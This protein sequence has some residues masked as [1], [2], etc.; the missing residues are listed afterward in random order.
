MSLATKRPLEKSTVTI[1]HK[2]FVRSAKSGNAT[3]FYREQYLREDIPCSSQLCDI[4]AKLQ[5]AKAD[6]TVAT[7]VLARDP[8]VTTKRGPHYIIID[9]NIALQAMDVLELKSSFF[10]MIIPQTVL[11]EVRNR[12]MPT[13]TRLRTLTKDSDEKRVY[14][15]HNEF[16]KETHTLR[17]KNETINDRNDRAIRNVAK[18]YSQHIKQHAA[19]SAK[20]FG[21]SVPEVVLLSNDRANRQKAKEEGITVLSLREYIRELKNADDI[22]D[23]LPS[24]DSVSSE[25]EFS[26]PEYYP[27]SRILGGVKN[28]TLFRGKLQINRYNFLEGTVAT[29]AYPRPMLILGRKNLNRGFDGDTVV[30]ELLP[31]SQWKYPVSEVVEEERLD[32]ADGAD[33]E[34][35]VISDTERK[36]LAQEALKAQQDEGTSADGEPAGRIQ[37]TARIVSI[38][39]RSWRFYVGHITANS[40]PKDAPDS[41]AM[42]SVFV[43][44]LNKCIP[45]IRIY[46]RKARELVGKRIVIAIDTWKSTSKHPDGHFVRLLGEIESKEAET[47]AIL[48][49]HDVEYRP[50]PKAVLDCLPPEGHDWRVPENLEKTIA[51]GDKQLAKRKDL[52][53]L[54]V[55][56]I[57]PPKCQDIDDALHARPLPNGN[58]EVGVHIADVTHFVK[59]N[60][61]LDTEGAARGTS[62]YLVDKR[63]DM[64]PMLLGTD[65]CSL[66]SD[67]DRFAF[68]VIWELTPDANIVNVE[69]TKSIIRSC[70]S[71]EYSE[72]QARIDDDSNTDDLTH[73]MRILLKL[74]K[75]LKQQRYD[76]GALNL[77]SPEVK[78]HTDSE[79]ADPNEVEIKQ[80]LETNSLV[81]EFML[82]ANISVARK[83]YKA[84][85][86]T[87]MLRRHAAP[88]ATNFDNLNDQLRI[89]GES[90]GKQ[91][92]I[93]VTS[94]KALA[95]SLDTIEDPNDPYFNTVVR[96]MA[97]RCMM[98]AEYF[99]SGDFGEADFR[100]YGLASEIY[101]H[102]TSPIRRYADVVAHRQLAAAIEYEPLEQVHR[103]KDKMERICSNI[104][105]RHRNAQ[106]AGR[107]SIEYFVGQVLK[108]GSNQGSIQE[109]YVMKTFSN[110]VVIFVPKF[111][112][113]S[114]I[115]LED[116]GDPET[117]NY[118]EETFSLEI[119]AKNGKGVKKLSIFDK[120]SVKVLSV[121][122]ES[123]GNR[124][125]KMELAE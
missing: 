106:F 6:G 4:C 112:V 95:D 38:E 104:N 79:T 81:E 115:H 14:V 45:R 13:Y 69:F 122:D 101:T 87:A 118:S 99:S 16:R 2:V 103:D 94:S 31:K 63:I 50:F 20:S 54:L 36:M 73:G 111:G 32:S 62:V 57:D 117:A 33:S 83:I 121:K 119:S 12:S 92:H 125:V 46:T 113:E 59:A 39:K 26:Y 47:E 90:I 97:T 5:P 24:E 71:F 64:L 89:K 86:Q 53:H 3:K 28:G 48:L 114:L 120:I 11:E 52:R 84:F 1:S 44:P 105:K 110:G 49:E 68:S 30:V 100:H 25:I 21:L 42:R 37:P 27:T 22:L 55:C 74:S 56:S 107:A 23:M 65:L 123:S 78:V 80:L 77:A 72:A 93:D 40:V 15:F 82:L 108:N 29:H 61:P 124:K 19:E 51:A 70:Q 96:I 67:V 34:T 109:G 88:P 58:F 7:P 98:S 35:F 60:T 85:P 116:L 9:T 8:N 66:K 76:A 43:S 17:L 91:L 10:D 41:N 75:R 102:F 18:Y